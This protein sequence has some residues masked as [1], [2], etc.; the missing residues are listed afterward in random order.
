VGH[1]LETLTAR[2]LARVE[3]KATHG[4]QAVHARNAAA[5]GVVADSALHR[6]CGQVALFADSIG[7]EEME[8]L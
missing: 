8:A 1:L 4:A 7:T 6:A 5:I 2:V 3:G